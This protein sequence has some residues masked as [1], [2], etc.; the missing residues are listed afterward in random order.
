M[1]VR[2]YLQVGLKRSVIIMTV[3]SMALM[4]VTATADE[5]GE[6]VV[7]L[8]E[9][10]HKHSETSGH[11]SNLDAQLAT[12]NAKIA[13]T[14]REISR[15]NAGIVDAKARLAISQSKL[16]ELVRVQYQENKQTKLEQLVGSKSFSEFV[17]REQYLKAGQDKIAAAVYE[18]LKVRKELEAKAAELGKLNAELAAAQNGLNFARA[19]AQNEL[20]ALNAAR[21]ELKKKLARYQGGRVVNAGDRV[22]AGDLIGFEGSSGCSTG[23]HLHFEVQQNGNPVSPRSLVPGRMRWPQDGFVVNQ[24]FGRP[25]WAA[26]YSF[27]GGIDMSVHFGAPVFAAAA[28]TV[29]FSGYNRTGFGDHVIIN[30]G[31]GL[32]SIYGH[33]GARASDYPSC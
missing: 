27:H 3:V 23:S 2:G 29:E 25:N 18:V 9:A 6:T 33:L 26:P 4:P 22:N 8:N 7:K 19:Q 16:N 17:D 20:N 24:E 21:E 12:I 1:I 15:T 14:Q 13:R 31:N 30:H 28:G 5:A 32:A 11:I 10:N